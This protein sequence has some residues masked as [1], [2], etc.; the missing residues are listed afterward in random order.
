M[1]NARIKRIFGVRWKDDD[2]LL[3]FDRLEAITQVMDSDWT[4]R[5]M[6]LAYCVFVGYTIEDIMVVFGLTRNSAACAKRDIIRK[7]GELLKPEDFHFIEIT[8]EYAEQQIPDD[9]IDA[10]GFVDLLGLGSRRVVDYWL[11]LHRKAQRKVVDG[12]K[13]DDRDEALLRLAYPDKLMGANLKGYKFWWPKEEAL[14][15]VNAYLSGV[16]NKWAK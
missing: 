12:E 15:W 7:L 1:N 14:L 4:E 5:Q 6:H 13:L 8:Q 3:S 16:F 9:G 11:P 10:N 2:S